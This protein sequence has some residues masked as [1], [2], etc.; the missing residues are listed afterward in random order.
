MLSYAHRAKSK[1]KDMQGHARTRQFLKGTGRRVSLWLVIC[2]ALFWWGSAPKAAR[3]DY[4]PNHVYVYYDANHVPATSG[5]LTD[6][7]DT[8][9]LVDPYIW[10]F[11]GNC[12]TLDYTNHLIYDSYSQI[13]GFIYQGGS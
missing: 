6:I 3:A 2:C 11:Y 10:D 9:A 8:S 4:I 5:S 1:E 13:V 12:L 7:A